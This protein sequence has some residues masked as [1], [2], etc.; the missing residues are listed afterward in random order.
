MTKKWEIY[1]DRTVI[2]S[3]GTKDERYGNLDT[4]ILDCELT[5]L[6]EAIY[7]NQK[8]LDCRES[9]VI[10]AN[11]LDILEETILFVENIYLWDADGD[12]TTTEA[13]FDDEQINEIYDGLVEKGVIQV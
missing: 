12:G 2:Y 5:D 6:I 10:D 4:K 3:D 11:K 7:T 9:D 13:E 8:F 1:Y